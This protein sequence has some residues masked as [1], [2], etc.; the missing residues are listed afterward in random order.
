MNRSGKYLL[1]AGAGAAAAAFWFG[2]IKLPPP[3][4][5]PS[6]MN[7]PRVIP[8][9]A[10]AQ[11]HLP[12]GFH[13]EVYARGFEQPRY[14]TLGP[15]GEVLLADSSDAPNGAIYLL[16]PNAPPRKLL[17]G[18]NK[19]YGLAFHDG[20]LYVGQPTEIVRCRYDPAAPALSRP[21]TV[22]PMPGFNTDH[23]TRTITFSPDGA[24]MYVAVGS[25]SNDSPGGPPERA[26][27]NRYNPDGSG[28]EIFAS[29]LRN[30]VGLR[31]Y[32][33][34]NT[35]WASV[36]ERDTFG[37]DLVPDFFTH[38][39]QGGFYGWPYAYIGPHPDPLNGSQ[40]PDLVRTTITPD[41]VFE[42]AHVALLD[43][44]FYTG[45]RF[46]AEYRGGAFVAEHGSWNRSK[47][48]GYAVAFVPF[49]KGKPSGP[50]RDFITGWMLSPESKDV[51]GRP[52]G[53]LQ[54][55]DGS[56]LVSD[57]GA[58]VVWHVTY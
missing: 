30:P 46:P 5:T 17:T 24:K 20:Y 49:S 33:G 21:E 18:L 1:S 25:G 29:G 10:G 41:V 22:V 48:V 28:H 56:L 6:A 35:L 27:V 45:V 54:L 2:V 16:A 51:W 23:W 38:L 3:F 53:L 31:F 12:P 11:L 14:M 42:P 15:R 40:R 7:P 57:D 37:D 43:F 39:E 47:R 52:V 44:I 9:P 8:R 58:K 13:I 4:A 26:A 50:P 36:E 32:P 19:P 55:P 34:T